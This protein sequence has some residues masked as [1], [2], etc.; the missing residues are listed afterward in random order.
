M[1][2]LDRKIGSFPDML[3]FAGDV[4][5]CMTPTG[6]IFKPAFFSIFL[7]GGFAQRLLCKTSSLMRMN[8]T[9]IGSKAL[10][11]AVVLNSA[12]P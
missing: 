11:H 7:I 8:S 9:K 3:F 4:F 10:S 5:H 2:C 1:S 6:K 12:V